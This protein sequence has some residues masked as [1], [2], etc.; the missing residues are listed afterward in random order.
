M[1][2]R[3]Y[4]LELTPAALR[5][6]ESL[7]RDVQKR[8]AKKIDSLS[9]NPRPAGVVAIKGGKGLLRMR[10]GVYRVIYRIEDERLVVLLVRIGH[11]KEIYR[12]M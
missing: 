10:I 6:L 8:I 5:A 1:A 9:E 4:S 3:I 7:P 2:A 11:R 12:Q